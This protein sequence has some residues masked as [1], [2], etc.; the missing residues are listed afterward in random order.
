MGFK[1]T[2]EIRDRRAI[3]VTLGPKDIKEIRGREG[4]QA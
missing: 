1:V 4:P 3:W 2:E